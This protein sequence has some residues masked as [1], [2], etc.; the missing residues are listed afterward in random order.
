MEPVR[1]AGAVVE[2]RGVLA[3]SFAADRGTFGANGLHYD[4]STLHRGGLRL[5]GWLSAAVE[6]AAGNEAAAVAGAAFVREHVTHIAVR[7]IVGELVHGDRRVVAAEAADRH[8]R[9]VVI[10]DERGG[11][12]GARSGEVP[13]SGG[14]AVGRQETR[15]RGDSAIEGFGTERTAGGALAGTGLWE[16]GVH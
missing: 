3:Y 9:D 16:R 1:R 7:H 13:A 8:H 14:V 10:G 11:L 12:L 15:Q 2:V 5:R 4:G 6:R